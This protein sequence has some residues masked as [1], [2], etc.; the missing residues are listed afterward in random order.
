MTSND[1]MLTSFGDSGD[2]D[3]ITYGD[4]RR[5]RITRLGRIAIIKD[6]SNSNVL[7]VEYL[8][9]NLLSVAQLCDFG[10]MCTFDMYCVIVF[11]EKRQIFD[12]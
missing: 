6:F 11:H 5:G 10:L 2:H 7:Y 1:S 4:N 8:S 3:H 9:F 12:I